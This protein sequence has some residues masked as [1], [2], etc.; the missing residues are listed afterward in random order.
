MAF[1]VCTDS[2][3]EEDRY[4]ILI[5]DGSAENAVFWDGYA[6]NATSKTQDRQYR[7]TAVMLATLRTVRPA[8]FRWSPILILIFS[9]EFI[10]YIPVGYCAPFPSSRHHLTYDNCLEDKTENY[11]NCSVLCCV[12]QLCTVIRTHVSSS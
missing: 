9:A 7:T 4:V 3:T 2:F 12:R 10:L 8:V 11:Q 1:N 5:A 6:E